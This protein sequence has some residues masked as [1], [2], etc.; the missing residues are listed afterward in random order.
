MLGVCNCLAFHLA[1]ERENYRYYSDGHNFL[2]CYTK[3][4]ISHQTLFWG[5]RHQHQVQEA[6][7]SQAQQ[8]SRNE[9]DFGDIG[10][11]KTSLNT[12]ILILCFL[13]ACYLPYFIVVAV[14]VASNSETNLVIN[15]KCG[16]MYFNSLI[17]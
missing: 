4:S 17:N 3:L 2:L 6:A 13:F 16:N 8:I 14:N 7:N 11:Y 5:Q 9:S 1:S 15:I 12:L 10:R